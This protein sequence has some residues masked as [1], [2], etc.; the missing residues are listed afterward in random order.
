MMIAYVSTVVL[1]SWRNA[2]QS[3][4]TPDGSE[5]SWGGATPL[6]RQKSMHAV[7]LELDLLLFLFRRIFVL[8]EKYGR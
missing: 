8:R 4:L 3:S 1:S 7:L 5:L 6:G 2:L